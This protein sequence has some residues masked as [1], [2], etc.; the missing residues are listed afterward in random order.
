[1]SKPK[2]GI[3]GKILRVK[4]NKIPITSKLKSL[5]IGDKKEIFRVVDDKD[6][7]RAIYSFH[8]YVE[9]EDII[10][11]YAW[12]AAI[13]TLCDADE[14]PIDNKL[15]QKLSNMLFSNNI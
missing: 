7:N 4:R 14:L 9:A 12:Y 13:E 6:M 15:T 3:E 11:A 5:S 8:Y 10:L 1:M 2:I